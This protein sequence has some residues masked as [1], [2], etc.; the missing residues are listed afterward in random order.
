MMIRGDHAT[1]IPRR[2]Q[3][4]L[5]VSYD[6]PDLGDASYL[7]IASYAMQ[8]AGREREAEAL[9]LEAAGLMRQFPPDKNGDHKAGTTV[10]SHHGILTASFFGNRVQ[11]PAPPFAADGE[12]AGRRRKADALRDL[13]FACRILGYGW[14]PT[15]QV[16]ETITEKAIR[17][18]IRPSLSLRKLL[19]VLAAYDTALPQTASRV[20]GE[21]MQDILTDSKIRN[22]NAG[23]WYD[24]A[25]NANPNLIPSASRK[26]L[27]PKGATWPNDAYAYFCR[28]GWFEEDQLKEAC[29]AARAMEET[30]YSSAFRQ[31]SA[32][33]VPHDIC[34]LPASASHAGKPYQAAMAVIESLT[35]SNVQFRLMSELALDAID[36]AVKTCDLIRL[37]TALKSTGSEYADRLLKAARIIGPVPD[38][39]EHAC[40]AAGM[41]TCASVRG[42]RDGGIDGK[43]Y[44]QCEKAIHDMLAAFEADGSLSTELE[45]PDAN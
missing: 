26:R 8:Q 42:H 37:D 23:P 6:D 32:G 1:A 9:A 10:Y 35:D 13:R 29:L 24:I 45:E 41:L 12:S 11:V 3:R 30:D 28:F 36:A 20:L 18:S 16:C 34:W 7:I 39:P 27:V 40:V 19:P 25:Q 44:P 33:P 4:Q 5:P 15:L 22:S 17:P 14:F 31:E 2:P 43:L 21:K 38:I